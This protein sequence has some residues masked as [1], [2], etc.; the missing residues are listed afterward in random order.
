MV[1][2]YSKKLT[3]RNLHLP[4]DNDFILCYNEVNAN[5]GGEKC[6]VKIYRKNSGKRVDKQDCK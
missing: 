5:F 3:K 1:H 2:T 6:M 4:V